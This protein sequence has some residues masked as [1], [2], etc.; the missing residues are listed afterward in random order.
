MNSLKNVHEV[1]AI[2]FFI[3]AFVYIFAIL[4]FRNQ[5][6]A[7]TAMIVMRI[8]DIPFALVA[9]LYGGSTLYL[10]LNENEDVATAWS[11]I[12]AA[13]CILLFALVVFANFAFPSRI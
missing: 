7:D 8:S 6:A 13:V 9:L 3:F 10:Q 2:Y 12:I 4:A 11:I 1:S 5:V